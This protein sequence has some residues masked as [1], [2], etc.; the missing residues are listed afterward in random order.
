MG[1]VV[2]PPYAGARLSSVLC[3]TKPNT[4]LPNSP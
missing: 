2:F 3:P 4:V 1:L